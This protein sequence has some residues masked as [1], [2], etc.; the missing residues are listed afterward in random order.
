MQ[1][2]QGGRIWRVGNSV[3]IAQPDGYGY[4]EH[5]GPAT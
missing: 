4:G 3:R 1:Q 5:M 2:Q